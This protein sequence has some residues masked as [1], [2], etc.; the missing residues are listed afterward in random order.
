MT[1]YNSRQSKHAARP[2]GPYS[3]VVVSID[4]HGYGGAAETGQE[5][6]GRHC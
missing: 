2:V 5:G 3:G 4:E 1:T 6:L